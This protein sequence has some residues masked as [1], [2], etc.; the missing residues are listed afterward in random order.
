MTPVGAQQTLNFGETVVGSSVVR[1]VSQPNP[2]DQTL[3][4]TEVEIT[5]SDA[6]QFTVVDGDAP[7][8][9]QA[10]ESRTISIQFSPTSTGQKSA[11]VQ[12]E[13][14]GS[15]TE[16][17]GQLTGSGVNE[18][19]DQNSDIATDGSA[20][21]PQEDTNESTTGTSTDTDSEDTDT[22]ER[23]AGN[24]QSNVAESAAGDSNASSSNENGSASTENENSSIILMLDFND[25]GVVDFQDIL[26]LVRMI[27]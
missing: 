25:N 12:V 7:F 2:T 27:G 21:S 10:N 16:T 23:E 6:D 26:T 14:A 24:T 9:L 15:A 3:P 18:T 11:S 19:G 20:S 13:I 22:T 5:G 8:T 17:A 4:I 1:T